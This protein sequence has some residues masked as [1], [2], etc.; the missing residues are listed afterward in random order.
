ML[1]GDH[2]E[3]GRH[4]RQQLTGLQ[5]KLG[6]S[7]S[8]EALVALGKRL[9]DQH[10]VVAAPRRRCRRKCFARGSWSPPR[11]RTSARREASPPSL[12]VGFDFSSSGCSSQA[13]AESLDRARARSA[14]IRGTIAHGGRSRGHVEHAPAGADE[15]RKPHHPARRRERSRLADIA[16]LL[17]SLFEIVERAPAIISV[18][19]QAAP[20][21]PLESPCFA[22]AARRTTSENTYLPQSRGTSSYSRGDVGDAAA[23]HDGVRVQ[24]V[25]DRRERSRETAHIVQADARRLRRRARRA[26]RSAPRRTLARALEVLA[27][28]RRTREERLD[29]AASPAPARR[30]GVL[31]GVSHGSGLWPH[32]PAIASGPTSSWPADHDAAARARAQDDAEHRR[33]GRRRAPGARG[34]IGRLRQRETVGVV[35]EPHRAPELALPDPCPARDR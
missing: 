19:S 30:P 23:E 16:R 27:R 17:R 15:V 20:R 25:D 26:R 7:R 13:S 18:Q 5:Q 1:V 11:R 9:V 14:R 2:L 33:T 3:P 12:Q 10:S 4:A 8:P 28:Q 29:A 22:R 24:H 35:G 21:T 31:L 32:S 34:A 6:P